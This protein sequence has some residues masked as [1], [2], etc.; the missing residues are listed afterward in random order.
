MITKNNLNKFLKKSLICTLSI[1]SLISLN[2]CN[3]A[4]SKDYIDNAIA[5]VYQDEKPYLINANKETYAL[6]YYE[7]IEQ[8]FNDYIAVKYEGKYG[9]IDKTGKQT[10]PT[11]YDKVYPMSEEKAI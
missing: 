9:F 4:P 1:T 5:I 8:S 3:N 7:E 6:D 11:I 10:V 2:S